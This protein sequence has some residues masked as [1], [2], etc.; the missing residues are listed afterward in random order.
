M[1]RYLSYILLVFLS[2]VTV[3]AEES[4]AK[5]QWRRDPFNLPEFNDRGLAS[6]RIRIHCPTTLKLEGVIR[7][8]KISQ[9]FINGD[10]FEPG[11]HVKGYTISHISENSVTLQNKKFICSLTLNSSGS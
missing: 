11:Q 7:G 2:C 9:A 10:I 4:H 3:M 6:E 5:I 8:G 1:I